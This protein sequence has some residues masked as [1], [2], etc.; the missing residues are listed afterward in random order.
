M[1]FFC[2]SLPAIDLPL[3]AT[4]CPPTA[5]SRQVFRPVGGEP[6][7][8]AALAAGGA[9]LAPLQAAVFELVEPA[10]GAAAVE[11]ATAADALRGRVADLLQPRQR[12]AAQVVEGAAT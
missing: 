1:R 10:G 3:P 12:G 8:V 6:V 2:F 9:D 11:R 4:H 5:F 7:A